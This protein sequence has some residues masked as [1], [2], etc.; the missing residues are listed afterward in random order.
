MYTFIFL[1]FIFST[2]D[3]S[4][5]HGPNARRKSFVHAQ[6]LQTSS[7]DNFLDSRPQDFDRRVLQCLHI[8]PFIADVSPSCGVLGHFGFEL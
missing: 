5:G 1:L 7:K 8:V 2:F 4:Q 3:S 6:H